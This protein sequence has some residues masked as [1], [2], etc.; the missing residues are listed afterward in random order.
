VD[1]VEDVLK[2]DAFL[3]GALLLEISVVQQS[4]AAARD[5]SEFSRDER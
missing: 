4:F 2:G 5:D 3:L 1:E